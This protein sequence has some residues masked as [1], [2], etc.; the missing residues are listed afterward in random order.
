M[1]KGRAEPHQQGQRDVFQWL[2]T[3][4]LAPE[5]RPTLSEFHDPV[6][7]I[8]KIEKEASQ[9]GICK[10]IPPVPPQL[11]KTSL[12]NLNRS[13]AARAPDSTPTFTTRQQQIGFCPR[14]SCPVQR[15]VWQSGDWYKVSDFEAKAKLFEK[16][17]LKRVGKKAGMSPLEMETLYWKAT[18]DKPFT[19]E[20]AND[21]PGSAFVQMKG[22][23][24]WRETGDG[25]NVG[26][27][28]WNMRGVSRSKLSLLR[29]LKE[30]IPGVTSPMVYIAM[31]FSWF[32][33]HAEDHDMHSLNYLHIGASKTWYGVPRDAASSFEEVV[34]VQGYGGEINPIATFATLGEKTTVMSPEIFIKAGIPCCRLVQ[35]PG[36]FVVTFPR[37]YHTGFS[38]GFNVGEAANFATPEWLRVAKEAATRRA[39][40]KFPPLVSHAQLL[41]DLV[42]ALCSRT[43]SINHGPRSSRLK[44]KRRTEGETVVK[45]LFVQDVMQ[46]NDLLYLLGQGS[47]IVTLPES[48]SGFSLSLQSSNGSLIDEKS[49]FGAGFCSQ[50]V[51]MAAAKGVISCDFERHGGRNSKNAN[52]NFPV[53]VK[54]MSERGKPTLY[55]GEDYLCSRTNNRLST[56]QKVF[57][58]VACGGLCFPCTAI[59]QPSEAAERYTMSADRSFFHDW[60]VPPGIT[61]DGF[62][63]A[64][65]GRNAYNRHF[66]SV[67]REKRSPSNLYEFQEKN[68]NDEVASEVEEQPEA[69]GAL[70]L[71]AS[72]YANSSDSDDEQFQTD[73][74]V[75]ADGPNFSKVS[76]DSDFEFDDAPDQKRDHDEHTLRNSETC[77]ENLPGGAFVDNNHS[78]TY[79]DSPNELSSDSITKSDSSNHIASK[80]ENIVYPRLFDSSSRMHIFCLEH[81]VEVKSQLQKIGGAHMLLLCH[82]DYPRIEAEAK[83][84]AEE[85]GLYER[86]NDIAFRESTKEDEACIET[87]LENEEDTP[88][89]GDWAVKL[90]IDLLYC[91]NLSR[92]SLYSKQMP[93]NSIIYNAFGRALQ[94][95]SDLTPKMGKRVANKQKRIKLAGKW[96]GK[97]WMSNQVHPMLMPRDQEEPEEEDKII[98]DWPEPDDTLDANPSDAVLD[99]PDTITDKFGTKRKIVVYSRSN[100]RA[101]VAEKIDAVEDPD[102]AECS[103]QRRPT[104]MV[105]SR[106]MKSAA[107]EETV[108]TADKHEQG[109]TQLVSHDEYVEGG[110]STRLRKRNPKFENDSEPEPSLRKLVDGKTASKTPARKPPVRSNDGRIKME[111]ISRSKSIKNEQAPQPRIRPSGGDALR[112][113]KLKEEEAAAYQCDI[114]GCTMTFNVKQELLLHKRNICPV[115]GCGKK[116][117]SHKYLVQHK[118]VH[119]DDRPLKC[120]WKG[121][122]M[123]FKWAWARTE[124]IRVHTGV[125]P[126]ICA[127]PGCGQT[128]RFVSDFSRH[129][130]KTGHSTKKVRQ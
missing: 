24:K 89:N 99:E 130:R 35:N 50:K 13:L 112:S 27:T 32:A 17:Y 106:Y 7:Y 1:E 70:G 95:E 41:Y 52:I 122:K 113:S 56:D 51:E 92:S 90:G 54:T 125:R 4:P 34:R 30:D 5:Y 79:L 108:K 121:C 65:R 33:W 69:F 85:V 116:F 59:I 19:V 3:L 124:H 96:C 2:K 101:K 23:K 119:V 28:S 14:K 127:E 94:D 117:F 74:P 39:A 82:P 11:K 55:G 86:W 100:K 10:I 111:P 120:P 58:C 126:Y 129:K 9:F 107:T 84:V 118:R 38:H 31:M 98:N 61:S 114:E 105:R 104:R 48:S 75:F 64:G 123:A 110:P 44:D 47:Y 37:A 16:N 36:E 26:E 88:R 87:V 93:Y 72:A 62:A 29:F 73:S 46:N 63:V 80:T 12:A 71:L 91:A 83:M 76:A 21:M 78:S 103:K 60:T 42:F 25:V 18:V 15:P 102:Q 81:A 53:Q 68:G 8:F 115:K 66:S 20:Y 22:E 43:S 40:I 57:S 67:W 49:S 45:Q 97:V 109:S 77:Q 128:F 6:S